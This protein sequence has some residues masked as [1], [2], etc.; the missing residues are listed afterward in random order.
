DQLVAKDLHLFEQDVDVDRRDER[1]VLGNQGSPALG[2]R[3]V[4][5]VGFIRGPV[6]AAA[7]ARQNHNFP[8]QRLSEGNPRGGG[9]YVRIRNGGLTSPSGLG[10]RSPVSNT[11]HDQ[12]RLP[13]P[14]D[15]FSYK[16]FWAKRLTPAPFLPMSAEEMEAL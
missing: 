2:T 7:H 3:P 5:R 13:P 9:C 1:F 11:A 6:P 12:F 10:K 4:L 14:K 15:I 16:P 8:H